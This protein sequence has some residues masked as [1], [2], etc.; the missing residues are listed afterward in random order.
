M[1]GDIVNDIPIWWFYLIILIIIIVYRIFRPRVKGVIG[2]KTIAAILSTLPRSQYKVLNNVALNANGK[3]SQ[4][5]HL[6]ISN[7][8]IFV[9]ET[10]NYK[11]WI[12]GG[13]KSEYWT[14][15]IYSRKEKFYNP[16]RQNY[17]HINALKHFLQDF[18]NIRY[19][20][21]VVFSWRATLKVWT[22][23]QVTYSF[24]LLGIIKKYEE[25]ILGEYEKNEIFD[26]ISAV[27]SSATYNRNQHIKLIKQKIKEKNKSIEQGYC[28]Q[29]GGNLVLR[30]GKFGK[31]QGCS[32]FPRCRNTIKLQ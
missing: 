27:N 25:I 30:K 17:G 19:F 32:N 18:P 23:S 7:F 3:T 28:P 31:F 10:K 15:V 12:L 8:G 14:Q 11:G 16:I 5:D 9:I 6:I 21:I 22:T 2:E 4:I 20:P 13:E 24:K 26:R 1:I 29:C